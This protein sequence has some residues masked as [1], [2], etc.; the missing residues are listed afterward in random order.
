[1]FNINKTKNASI[2]F[3]VMGMVE[4]VKCLRQGNLKI[5]QMEVDFIRVITQLVLTWIGPLG[6]KTY[7]PLT[8]FNCNLLSNKTL[9]YGVLSYRIHSGFVMSLSFL[10]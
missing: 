3:T 10:L 1:M 6:N 2:S 9:S 5:K 8:E 7:A 4:K